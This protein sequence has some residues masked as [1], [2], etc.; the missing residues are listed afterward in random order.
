MGKIG[1]EVTLAEVGKCCPLRHFEETK[2]VEVDAP[3]ACWSD[4]GEGG[5][6]AEV[7]LATGKAAERSINSPAP[8]RCN[9]NCCNPLSATRVTICT[10][11]RD[12]E[13]QNFVML[14]TNSHC[15]FDIS[16]SQLNQNTH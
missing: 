16:S 7:H 11:T 5:G 9:C 10:M 3:T 1:R 2:L 15:S 6:E 8:P 14:A 4:S 12:A 13:L